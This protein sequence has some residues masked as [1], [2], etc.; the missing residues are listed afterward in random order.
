MLAIATSIIAYWLLVGK[1]KTVMIL[2]QLAFGIG[3]LTDKPVSSRS[4]TKNKDQQS[5]LVL[6]WL[7]KHLSN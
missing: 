5:N 6:S 7:P 3:K 1:Y 2:W 4:V